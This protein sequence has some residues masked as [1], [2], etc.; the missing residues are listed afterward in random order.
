MTLGFFEKDILSGGRR[1]K[2]SSLIKTVDP[3]VALCHDAS[4]TC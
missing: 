3:F 1:V 2:E 4:K